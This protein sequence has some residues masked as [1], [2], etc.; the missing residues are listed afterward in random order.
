MIPLK[1]KNPSY[2][3]PIVN[4]ILIAAN[5]VVFFYELSLGPQLDK[6][7]INYGLVPSRYFEMVARHTHPITRY[8]PFLTSMFIHGGW[9]HIIGNMWFLFIFGDNVEDRFGHRRYFFFYMLSGLA[10]AALQASLS[11][12]SSI[13]TIGASGAISGVLG[14]Y[15]VLFPRAKIVTLIPIFFIFDI[16][17]IS[18]V[19][20]IGFWFL[21]QFFSG[22]Q[23]AGLD[24]SGGI[25]WWAHVGGFL[26][27][28]LMVPLFKRRYST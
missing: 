18:A 3:V 12:G 1:D 9:L 24:T 26:A 15:L 8:L 7:Y 11:A 5:A 25:A 27:G 21:M 10:A 4:Y 22:I 23:S 19:L 20:F 13:P 16:I 28:I 14:A 6:F 2:S 17:D